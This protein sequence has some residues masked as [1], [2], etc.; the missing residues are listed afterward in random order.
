MRQKVVAIFLTMLMVLTMFSVNV[1]ANVDG[2]TYDLTDIP[3]NW[4]T[5]AL[6]EA[7][8][9]GLLSGY[10]NKLYPDNNLTRAEMATVIN[11]AFGANAKADIENYTD[12]NNSDWYYE[13]M[14]KAVGM[15]TFKG[16][17]NQ[18]RP[19]DPIT[20]EEVFVVL[21]NAMN[22]KSD[23]PSKSFADISE[24][25]QWAKSG[26]FALINNNYVSGS[27]DKLNP[28]SN[29]TRAEFAQVMHNIVKYYV[30]SPGVY[31]EVKEGNVI[32]N[33]PNVILKGVVIKGDLIIADGVGEGEVSLEGVK[34][35][36]RLLVRG[37]G[38]N[39]IIIKGDSEIENIIIVKN[40]NIVRIL[41]ETGKEMAVAS[42][43]GTADVILEGKY[44]NVVVQSPDITVYARDTVI[45]KVEI[46]GARSIV[47][48]D[49]DSKIGEAVVQGN[50]V[51]IEG[52]GEVREVEVLVGGSGTKITTPETLINV[53]KGA[54]DVTGTGG[55]VIETNKT[56]A[57]GKT[58]KEGAKPLKRPSTGGSTGENTNPPL[59]TY[60]VKYSVIG[61]GGTLT[62]SVENGA[63]V[64][65]GS[66]VHFT[67]VP[68]EGYRLK[69][70]TVNGE[71]IDWLTGLQVS[72]DM[73][74]DVDFKVGFEEIPVVTYE[75]VIFV[76]NV[77]GSTVTVKDAENKVIP[78]TKIQ[79]KNHFYDLE[80]G[81]YTY[82][83][84]KENYYTI[85]RLL[86]IT[87]PK[88]DYVTM[89]VVLP[90]IVSFVKPTL[91]EAAVGEDIA[92]RL[93]LKVFAVIDTDELVELSVTWDM[94]TF[95]NSI[96]DNQV[97]YGDF[98]LVEG[99]E[100]PMNIKAEQLVDIFAPPIV[101][102]DITNTNILRFDFDT[103]AVW[104]GEVP[105]SDI[106][107]EYNTLYFLR[108][109]FDDPTLDYTVLDENNIR[110]NAGPCFMEIE[111]M[112]NAIQRDLF[113][114][115]DHPDGGF[116]GNGD[117]IY[118]KDVA[119]DLSVFNNHLGVA[120]ESTAELFKLKF[121]V[122]MEN[123]IPNYDAPIT[124]VWQTQ[125][126]RDAE[127]DPVRDTIPPTLISYTLTPAPDS[128]GDVWVNDGESIVL[129]IAVNE[130]NLYKI[131]VLADKWYYADTDVYKDNEI[132]RIE[133][134]DAGVIVTYENNVLTLDL[135]SEVSANIT[136]LTSYL[137][138]EDYV[139]NKW[140]D[141]APEE[142]RTFSNTFSRL[143]RV[144]LNSIKDSIENLNPEDYTQ[145]S[146]D[147]LLNVLNTMPE[148]TQQEIEEKVAVLQMAIADLVPYVSV[149]SITID[150][151][152]TDMIVNQDYM[153]TATVNP[154]D[155]TNKGISWSITSGDGEIW[156]NGEFRA[157]APGLVV[158]R[159]TSIDNA[160]VYDELTFTAD[161]EKVTIQT[162]VNDP[163]L[164]SAYIEVYEGGTW[165]NKG[166]S[167]ELNK[168]TEGPTFRAR[169]EFTPP[170]SS[171]YKINI[172]GVDAFT[173]DMSVQ[174]VPIQDFNIVFYITSP[175]QAP[176][177]YEGT[178]NI[179]NE[180]S[181]LIDVLTLSTDPE[182]DILTLI[183][184][185]QGNYGT[186]AGFGGSLHYDP[187][188][189]FIGTDSFSYRISD[190]T[191]TVSGTITIIVSP[192]G[193]LLTIGSYGIYDIGIYDTSSGLMAVLH[194][195]ESTTGLILD[196][197]IDYLIGIEERSDSIVFIYMSS[198]QIK[199]VV[200]ANI[201]YNA[202]ELDRWVIQSNG[203]GTLSTVKYVVDS[204]NVI[205]FTYFDSEG[206]A[207]QYS[208][209][210]LM[211]YNTATANKEVLHYGY[212]ENMG[213]SDYINS[214][215]SEVE[216]EIA[217]DNDDNVVIMYVYRDWSTWIG[218]QDH[219]YY[220]KLINP[221][222]DA[223]PTLESYYVSRAS[224]KF[225]G[226]QLT[227]GNNITAE[228]IYNSVPYTRVFEGNGLTEQ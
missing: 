54:N 177:P 8:D 145:T 188:A 137:D 1:L 44:K 226:L 217:V 199:T 205:H 94:T 196:T 15:G 33:V 166:S 69:A 213:G 57:N 215:V 31:E 9:N 85:Q 184:F 96:A 7:V 194:N 87:G 140:S 181:R 70:W 212:R 83:V 72:R 162:S 193:D 219:T 113:Y 68:E 32:V 78:F 76:E 139:G 222:S 6:T 5:E 55:I 41:N 59:S 106:G 142:E 191:N 24:V 81:N 23:K 105:V 122:P 152:I 99:V 146:W 182:G 125:E 126:Q 200:L 16:Y 123:G 97:I 118:R 103:P 186:V 42:V 82:T 187:N 108:E 211:Y 153:L 164:G 37:G 4:S 189:G 117:G 104:F 119:V 190:G 115:L 185:E 88:T 18:L 26:V 228:Y 178:I 36:G 131:Y 121:S 176:I 129:Q 209:R 201:D 130:D 141:I 147:T 135:G 157:T 224:M 174:A 28:K 114:A 92:S 71:V 134:T 170:A 21:S 58:D 150:D 112:D 73:N 79:G 151:S 206:Q 17:E 132:N 90:G 128:E 91:I 74:M 171:V 192:S 47:I 52:N 155:A 38:E 3:N 210:D 144:E 169:V 40:G 127:T 160:S 227:G 198:N 109:L 11:R 154:E 56:Y 29:I 175:N 46:N 214:Y 148:T 172:N 22:L 30:K 53:A 163:L 49:E 204:N 10:N 202:A 197:V 111:L 116:T 35:E 86:T 34:V 95:D 25:S 64:L 100:N 27:G 101:T 221:N 75:V 48:V 62:A 158:V 84:E 225:S 107:L 77:D 159:A 19:N 14:S 13:E 67:A 203:G 65:A 161:Y 223:N 173:T 110:V 45:A 183:D 220:L 63:E 66:S 102:L 143:D 12:V 80:E 218:G 208:Q 98:V 51:T 20:R 216:P 61:T 50:G 138:F 133:E 207:D 179:D 43:E 167:V 39:S 89:E 156:Q 120:S 93:P 2:K 195:Q 149:E 180:G 136:S 60:T 165:I 124:G 168:Y